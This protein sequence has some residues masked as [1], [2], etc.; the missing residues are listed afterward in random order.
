M[1]DHDLLYSHSEK[2]AHVAN[3]ESAA[4]P[5]AGSRSD[6]KKSFVRHTKPKAPKNRGEESFVGS[7][8]RLIAANI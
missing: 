7:N 8:Y 3:V 4:F 5:D 6:T 1:S 2:D